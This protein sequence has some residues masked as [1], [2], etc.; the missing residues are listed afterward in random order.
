VTERKGCRMAKVRKNALIDGLSGS[1][2]ELVLKRARSGTTYVA[3]KPTFPDN[4]QFSAAQLAH[5]RRFKAAAAYAKQAAQTEP[6]Y[7]ALAKKT[8]QP[9]Y[10]VALADA[11]HPPR[12]IE[13]DASGYSGK[14]GE[15]IRVQAE[16]DVQ[17]TRVHVAI[18]DARE[19]VIEEGDAD[20]DHAG[21]WWTYATQTMEVSG[22]IKAT[23]YDLAEN[24]GS[25]I[26]TS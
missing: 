26:S 24:K 10:N 6:I 14:A 21:Q 2:G 7:A 11:M 4:R 9:A 13:I 20:S 22:N 5:Q 15:V 8:G 17:V 16:D 19:R 1:I 25:L 18:Y 12:V 3:R 23:A